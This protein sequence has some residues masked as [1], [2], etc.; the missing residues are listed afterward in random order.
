M[1]APQRCVSCLRS[2]ACVWGLLVHL[3]TSVYSATSCSS[4][5]CDDE[6][7]LRGEA[8]SSIVRGAPA[9]VEFELW[10][11][12]GG[13]P[14]ANRATAALAPLCS[15]LTCLALRVYCVAAA[16]S[17]DSN[18]QLQDGVGAVAGGAGG[19]IIGAVGDVVV[20]AAAPLSSLTRLR[21]LRLEFQ[22]K[23][24]CDMLRP[25]L[26]PLTSLI[27]LTQ[28]QVTEA[29]TFCGKVSCH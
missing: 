14:E 5:W 2:R 22:P 8:V 11:G 3:G 16:G 15:S 25:A 13:G 9:L 4:G 28:L 10:G 26:L 24:V 7:C 6:T 21:G 27:S 20:S 18:R 19:G 1:S 17:K 29:E 23:L 12:D